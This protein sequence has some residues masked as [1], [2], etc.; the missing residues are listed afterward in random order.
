MK[1]IIKSKKTKWVT[2]SLLTFLSQSFPLS[3]WS[4]TV[5]W[6]PCVPILL[7]SQEHQHRCV[8]LYLCFVLFCFFFFIK[9]RVYC[10]LARKGTCIKR[11]NNF[12]I[13][14]NSRSVLFF[15]HSFI[16]SFLH[17][18]WCFFFF[19]FFELKKKKK[20]KRKPLQNGIISGVLTAVTN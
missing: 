13:Y 16:A 14:N 20:K 18:Q 2:L 9:P 6:P 19:F 3:I 11:Y 12:R 4:S 5:L 17:Q 15:I 8:C 7:T 1:M 10:K